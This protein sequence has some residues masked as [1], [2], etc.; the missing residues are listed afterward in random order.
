[1][2]R[3]NKT[4]NKGRLQ[5]ITGNREEL[6]GFVGEV[7]E[8]DAFVTN[9]NGYQGDK[10]LVTEVKI[11][12]TNYFLKHIWLKRQK[13]GALPHGYTKLRLMVV[14]YVDHATNENKYGFK[15]MGYDGEL[16][17]D[18]KMKIPQWKLEQI[19]IE[20]ELK[21]SIKMKKEEGRKAQCRGPFGNIRKIK[22]VKKS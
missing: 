7:F 10:R 14:G 4:I 20:K 11:P 18:T 15:Y 16:K 19:E 1:M 17:I 8:C 13:I 5:E 3:E 22:I 21:E 9:T 2:K 12:G 6:K